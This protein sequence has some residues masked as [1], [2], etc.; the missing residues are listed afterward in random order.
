MMGQ[1]ATGLAHEINQPLAA[2]LRNAEAAELFL[3]H[4]TPDLEEIRAILA[5][6]RADDERAGHVIDRMRGL[7]K[8]RTLETR[9][10]DVAALVG[11]VAALVRVD[12]ASRQVKLD[13]VVPH[14]LP[15]VRGDRVHLQQVLLNLILNG[16]DAL[17]KACPEDRRVG[18]TARLNAAQAVEIVVNDAGPG[19]PADVLGQIFNPF[20]TTKSHGMGMGLAISRTIIE[21][22]D[23]QLWAENAPTGG[24]AFLFT[25]PIADETGAE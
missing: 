12:A 17:D 8:R 11:E 2:I 24:A 9:R 22:H 20:F 4:T 23:G 16:M 1:L 14:D 7:L 6:I 10:L 13:L 19:I 18:V 15:H 5:D 21:A 25:L 3:Q